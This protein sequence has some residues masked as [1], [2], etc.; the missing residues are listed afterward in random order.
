[1]THKTGRIS[2]SGVRRSRPVSGLA[3]FLLALLSHGL[4]TRF[5]G[6]IP[7][8]S[9]GQRRLASLLRPSSIRTMMI[10]RW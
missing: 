2:D 4:S 9:I 7:T 10:A 1:M 3:A 8:L 5:F 6:S